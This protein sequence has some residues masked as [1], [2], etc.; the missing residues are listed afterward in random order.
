[1]KRNEVEIG[2]T[3][4]AKVSGEITD[5]RITGVSH[6]GGWDGINVA[7][8]RAVRIRTAQRLRWKTFPPGTAAVKKETEQ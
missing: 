8:G 2:A 4:R 5:V 6:Y 7:T 1:M 3:Y